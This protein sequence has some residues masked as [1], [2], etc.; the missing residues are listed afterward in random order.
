MMTAVMPVGSEVNSKCQTP[1]TPK[2]HAEKI[3]S[4]AKVIH[5]NQMGSTSFR[6]L[7]V[8]SDDVGIVE[9]VSSK[10]LFSLSLS[11]HLRN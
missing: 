10:Q 1:L 8:R 5:S 11:R 3:K 2:S 9:E 4:P 7:G 6:G